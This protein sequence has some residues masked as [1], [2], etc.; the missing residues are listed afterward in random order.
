MADDARILQQALHVAGGEASDAPEIEA[1]E[2]R[3]K[4]LSLGQDGAPAQPGLKTLQAQLLEQA[5]IVP[6]RETPLRI[7]ILEELRRR[8]APAATGPAIRSRDRCT[9]GGVA[10]P[11]RQPYST[12]RWLSAAEPSFAKRTRFVYE[13]AFG[14]HGRGHSLADT[15]R[16]RTAIGD[17]R[18]IPR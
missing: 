4:I 3:P 2:R 11:F 6:D 16:V 7:V 13:Q 15:V 14:E 12:A 17:G 1:M 10:Y 5:P 8:A 9:H 18:V